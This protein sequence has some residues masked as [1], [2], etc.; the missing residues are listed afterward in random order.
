MKLDQQRINLKTENRK[1]ML[2]AYAQMIEDLD[3]KKRWE[4]SL[5]Q[6]CFYSKG[7]IAGQAFTSHECGICDEPMQ[8]PSTDVNALCKN[9][10]KLNTLCV[11]CGCSMRLT[12]RLKEPVSSKELE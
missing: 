8:F 10:A 11:H 7:R 9:C 12:K 5:C 3:I 1:A 2:N 6:I 4:A